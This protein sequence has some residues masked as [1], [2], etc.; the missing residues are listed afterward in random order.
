MRHLLQTAAVGAL[1]IVALAAPAFAELV[2]WVDVSGHTDTFST[3][4]DSLL[5]PTFTL[6]GVT[7]SGEEALAIEGSSGSPNILDDSVLSVT[8]TTGSA[9]S[10]AIVVSD[11]G[12][13]GPVNEYAAAGSG[14]WQ[15]NVGESITMNWYA[16]SADGQGGIGGATPGT[17]LTTFT[18]TSTSPLEGFS[19]SASG[20]FLATGPE[21]MTMEA[22][23]TLKGKG[24]LLNR[25]FN[26]SLSVVPEP[27]TWTMM[28]LGFAGLGYAAFR[29]AAKGRASAVVI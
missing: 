24:V 12:F 18:N 4:A 23:Y 28:L 25:G 10:I 2:I 11:T 17:K 19:S 6:D 20:G 14:T 22:S 21:S 27:S 5:L 26:E 29:R 7:I 15:N 8:N 16:D 1:A 3:S 9:K 13:T